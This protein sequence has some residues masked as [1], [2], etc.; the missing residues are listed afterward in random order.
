MGGL[1]AGMYAKEFPD[2][3]ASLTLVSALG[4]NYA[5]QDEFI[6][7]A[8]SGEK[9]VLMPETVDDMREMFNFSMHKAPSMPGT[10]VAGMLQI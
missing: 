4:V 9:F 10:V 1:I 2:Q 6:K 7:K 5:G 3:L 8:K